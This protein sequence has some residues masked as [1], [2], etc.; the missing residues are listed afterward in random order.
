M[1]RPVSRPKTRRRGVLLAAGA[2][3]LVVIAGGL[4]LLAPSSDTLAVERAQTQIAAARTASFD[5]YLPVRAQVAPLNVVYVT[6]LQGG[7]VK[8]VLARDGQR[9]EAGAPLAELSNPQL[10]LEVMSREAEI[11]G[12]LGDVNAQELSLQ[13]ARS[14]RDQQI[15]ETNYNLVR[16]RDEYQKRQRLF[17]ADIASPAAVKT[18]ADDVAYNTNRLATLRTQQAREARLSNE[19][20]RRIQET[21]EQLKRNLGF[22]HASLDALTIRAGAAGRLTNFDLQPG[23]PLAANEGV[24]QIDSD[25]AYKL[26]ADVDEFY[27]GRVSPDQSAIADIDGARVAVKVLRVLPQVVNGRFRVEFAFRDQPP[28]TLK[29]GQSADVRLTLGDTR[30]ALLLPNGAWLSDSGGAFAFVMT[31]GDTRAERRPIKI[32]RRNPDQVEIL[33]GVRPGDRVLVSSYRELAAYKHLI[34]R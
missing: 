10:Q 23:K 30:Q 18:F 29:R 5:D 13:R 3:A 24:G 20:R 34:L 27:L 2:A 33:E 7:V 14:D 26:T 21:A 8:Q 11:A 12:R 28:S 4:F 31:S 1:D 32:G 16:S 25:D 17:E 19:Q 22:I 6:A 15:A 9:V